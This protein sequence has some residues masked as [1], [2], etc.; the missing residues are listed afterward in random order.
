M[1]H[2]V[3]PEWAVVGERLG[4]LEQA[5]ELSGNQIAIGLGINRRRWSSYRLGERELPIS[6]AGELRRRYGCTLDWLYLG[7]EHANSEGFQQR[8]AEARRAAAHRDGRRRRFREAASPF[9][10]ARDR[11]SLAGLRRIDGPCSLN[12]RHPPGQGLGP[13]PREGGIL[14]PPAAYGL[15]SAGPGDGGGG[16]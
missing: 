6:L 1:T 2:E 3:R 4:W 16:P 9:R 5:Q 11:K 14:T 13:F 10:L 15:T 7:E 12:E 8:L